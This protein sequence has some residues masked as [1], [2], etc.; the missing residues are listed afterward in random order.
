[1]FNRYGER[2]GLRR[3]R[4]RQRA[5]PSRARARKLRTDV[6]ATL[7]LT[8]PDEYD[9]GELKSGRELTRSIGSAL[10]A[11]TFIKMRTER[12][13]EMPAGGKAQHTD[14][15][16]VDLPL[17]RASSHGADSSLAIH[18]RH[19]MHVA[20]AFHTVLEHK[21]GHAD[22]IEPIADIESLVRHRQAA[23]A[24]AGKNNNG[25]A[26]G[27]GRRQLHVQLRFMLRLGVQEFPVHPSPTIE[28]VLNSTARL[29]SLSPAK[30]MAHVTKCN[31]YKTVHYTSEPIDRNRA[32]LTLKLL[33]DPRDR[34]ATNFDSRYSVAGR[35][36]KNRVPTFARESPR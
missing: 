23:V 18:H 11:L 17:C 30:K 16:R 4:R 34:F 35:M 10:F 8:E 24:T 25:G 12:A 2:H 31:T 20:G 14:S 13:G 26:V 15:R 3:A 5:H 9:G 33:I 19:R 22:R 32:L 29:G 36:S 6:S 1:M 28:R 27:R 7:F 21:R